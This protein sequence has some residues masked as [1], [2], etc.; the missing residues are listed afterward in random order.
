MQRKRREQLVRNPPKSDRVHNKHILIRINIF[1]MSIIIKANELNILIYKYFLETGLSHSAYTLFNEAA[2]TQPLQ[3]DRFDV[4]AG[5]LM[6]VLEKGLVYN[7]LEAHVNMV[8][9][10]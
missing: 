4:K 8:E 5:H 1:Y 6:S 9:M 3:E 7:K 10:G 2:L